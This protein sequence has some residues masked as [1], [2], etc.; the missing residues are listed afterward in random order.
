M[1]GD[2]TSS[3]TLSFGND[4]YS[5]THRSVYNAERKIRLAQQALAVIRAFHPAPSLTMLSAIDIG[6]SVGTTTHAVAKYFRSIEGVDNDAHAI[7]FARGTYHRPNLRF[8]KQD[9]LSLSYPS[10]HFDVAICHEIYS[11][12][13]DPQKLMSEIYRILKP[14]GFCYFVGDNLL[15]PMESQYKIPFLL[16]LPDR[17][18]IMILKLT[19]KKK[20]YLGH[21]QSYWG[22][23]KL[24]RNFI[25]HDYT[26]AILQNPEKYKFT[27]LY[28][29]KKWFNHLPHWFLSIIKFF[30]PTYI[31]ILEKPYGKT[32]RSPNT[33]KRG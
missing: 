29:Y 10:N 19:G 17:L 8:A 15:F 4:Y 18:A 22:L 16:Y 33:R 9:A 7:H 1:T 23:R 3:Q 30:L 13:T 28:K 2:S 11:Y 26:L 14:G 25:I 32:S 6:C 12:V 27:R 20:Y 31:W 24:A 5:K 21:Y